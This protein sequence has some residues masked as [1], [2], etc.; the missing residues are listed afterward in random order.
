[1]LDAVAAT[2]AAHALFAPP[3]HFEACGPHAR[4]AHHGD[5]TREGEP[6]EQRPCPCDHRWLLGDQPHRERTDA[7]ACEI[8]TGACGVNL[9]SRSVPRFRGLVPLETRFIAEALDGRTRL[10]V[11]NLALALF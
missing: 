6:L 5:G 4:Y 9:H 10:R 1:E 7:G 11:L 2:Y 3:E 8:D